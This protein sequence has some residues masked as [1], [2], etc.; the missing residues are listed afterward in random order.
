MKQLDDPQMLFVD[1]FCG[2][3]GVTSGIEHAQIFEKKAARVIACV[4][5]DENAIAS[6]LENHPHCLHF[7]ED[8]RTLDVTELS[9]VSNVERLNYPMAKMCLWASLEC[10]NFSKAKGGLPRDADSRTLAEHLFRYLD[11]VTYDYIFIENVEEFM[12]W[13]PLDSKGKPLS[14]KRGI[15]YIKWVNN[16]QDYGFNYEYRIL[17]AADYGAH[18]SR[19][20]YFGVFARRGLPIKFPIATHGKNADSFSGIEKWKPVKEVL[21]FDDEGESIF[22]RKKPL[23]DRTMERIYAGL[24]KFVAKGDTSFLQKYYSGRPKGKVNSVDSPCPTLTTMN[25]VTLVNTKFLTYYYGNGYESSVNQPVGTLRTKDTCQLIQPEFIVQYNGQSTAV[26]V[27]NPCNALTQKDKFSLVHTHWIDRPFTD[28]GGKVQSIDQP[29]GAVLPVPKLNLVDAWVLSPHYDN[30]GTS[31]D[32]PSPTITANR[33]HH[34]LMF[35]Q[36]GMHCSHSIEKPSPVLPARMD[37]MYPYLIQ[38]DETGAPIAIAI[39]ETDSEVTKK[40]KV[41]MAA[42]G[43]IDIKMRMLRIKELKLITGFPETYVL[44]GTQQDQKKYIGNA[45][46]VKLAQ[47]IIE[48]FAA[49]LCEPL[50]NE[51][52]A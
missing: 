2:A 31:I 17:N 8:I 41:F 3:G 49:S 9:L 36:W 1:L 35:P 15:D 29:A 18:T 33:K 7:T 50:Q 47:A 46:P 26:S 37:K 12:A 45:V 42:Y 22:T 38:A 51:L 16:V 4:N 13:G 19:K 10:T 5:H 25:N 28:G 20:R 14:K 21:D 43:I 39:F 11:A 40:I 44:K 24:I 27:D 48:S 34:C 23:S 30:P 52:A 32:Q 6:H